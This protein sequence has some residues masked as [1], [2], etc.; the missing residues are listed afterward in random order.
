M[1]DAILGVNDGL[2]SMFLLVA[3]V[4]G[5]GLNAEQVLL[6]GVAGALAGAISMAAGE[7]VA[8]KSQEEVF[9]AEMEVERRHIEEHR[10]YER[11]ELR[12][13]FA[14]FGVPHERLDELVDILDSSDE[15]LLN[16]M[17]AVE[18]GLVESERRNPYLAAVTSG[19]LFLLGS[20][21]AVLPFVFLDEP[22]TGLIVALIL[23]S[24]G[25]FAVGAVKTL[26]T[27]K[28]LFV[29]GFENLAIGVV[30]AAISFGVG[31][32]FG[33]AVG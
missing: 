31:R 8:T 14:D 22:G 4:V 32:L 20:M 5:G 12:I 7:Y 17:A 16:V 29:S 6:T 26:I 11:D 18:F 10:D 30:G 19:L 25:L 2:V 24:I 13:M 21:P 9:E 28:N 23:S 1:R 3:G 15:S 33:V 27:R